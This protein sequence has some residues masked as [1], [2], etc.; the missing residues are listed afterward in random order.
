MLALT[1]HSRSDELW[2]HASAGNLNAAEE[3]SVCLTAFGGPR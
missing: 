3:F 2:G 1:S